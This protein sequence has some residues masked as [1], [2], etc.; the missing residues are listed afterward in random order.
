MNNRPIRDR[1]FGTRVDPTVQEVFKFF[2]NLPPYRGESI[3]VDGVR[4]R[5]TYCRVS[6]REPGVWTIRRLRARPVGW[7]LPAQDTT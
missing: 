3:L 6:W 5:V 4:H 2:P 1:L 7:W